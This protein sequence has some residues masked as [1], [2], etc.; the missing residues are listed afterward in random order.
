MLALAC[1]KTHPFV[2]SSAFS[3]P[4]AVNLSKSDICCMSFLKTVL[5]LH[6]YAFLMNSVQNLPNQEP[7]VGILCFWDNAPRFSSPQTNNSFLVDMHHRGTDTRKL[8]TR[9]FRWCAAPPPLHPVSHT[10]HASH[11]LGLIELHHRP[12]ARTTC[13]FVPNNEPS[14]ATC[15]QK[16]STGIPQLL[17]FSDSHA[18]CHMALLLPLTLHSEGWQR[19]SSLPLP[20]ILGGFWPFASITPRYLQSGFWLPSNTDNDAVCAFPYPLPC[21]ILDNSLG[22]TRPM[23]YRLFCTKPP[24]TTNVHPHTLQ[25]FSVHASFVNLRSTAW[26]GSSHIPS[27]N[28][29]HL[30][31]ASTLPISSSRPSWLASEASSSHLAGRTLSCLRCPLLPVDH[32]GLPQKH[33]LSHLAGRTLSCLRCPFLP[34]EHPGLLQKHF[35]RILRAEHSHVYAA[36]FFQ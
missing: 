8:S 20:I 11:L 17:C 32:R 6:H 34:V 24:S 30:C 29:S 16:P 13:V 1:A 23:S 19:D 28:P 5:H 26:I 33:L 27:F 21:C 7:R 4:S 3:L 18:L 2:S 25:C 10:S 15:F 22:L 9:L 36:H 14:V 35:F 12:T 31:L